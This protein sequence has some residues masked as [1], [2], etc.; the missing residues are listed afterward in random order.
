MTELERLLTEALANMEQVL[1]DTQNTQARTLQHHNKELENLK[2]TI[3]TLQT[4]Q[5]A[6]TERL[7]RLNTVY[8]NLQ[9][10]LTR[11]N[12]LLNGR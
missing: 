7:Q 2:I 4:E 3:S 5:L 10:L 8:E 6:L 1:H 11:L 12:G 9:P